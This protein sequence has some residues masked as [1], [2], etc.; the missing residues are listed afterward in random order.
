MSNPEQV[1][2]VGLIALVS[3]VALISGVIGLTVVLTAVPSLA[4][5]SRPKEQINNKWRLRD[6]FGIFHQFHP[7]T[8]VRSDQKSFA[9]LAFFEAIWPFF[10]WSPCVGGCNHSAFIIFSLPFSVVSSRDGEISTKKTTC[11]F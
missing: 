1:F 9:K 3:F 11:T 4:I 2:H 8:Q 10:I 7:V 6:F 5:S